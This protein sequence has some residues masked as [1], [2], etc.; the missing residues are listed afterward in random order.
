MEQWEK[1]VNIPYTKDLRLNKTVGCDKCNNNGYSGR[2]GI[3]ELL[4]GTEDQKKLVQ[5]S[6]PMAE[7]RAQ[8]EKDGM[9]TLK[10]DGIRKIFGGNI[11]LI[12]VRKVC[13]E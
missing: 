5:V 13:I 6:R 9:T 12:N 2:C 11:D 8:A 7:I 3:H 1:Y 4:M 10:Q